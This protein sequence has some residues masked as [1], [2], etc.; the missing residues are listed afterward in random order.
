MID[1][2]VY[3][4]VI[5]LQKDLYR[6]FGTAPEEASIRRFIKLTKFD[7]VQSPA[8][9]LTHPETFTV[10]LAGAIVVADISMS[11]TRRWPIPGL[12]SRLR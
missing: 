10:T 3:S 6:S 2:D 11:L 12:P 8:A 4:D 7:H 5:D 9:G 1:F